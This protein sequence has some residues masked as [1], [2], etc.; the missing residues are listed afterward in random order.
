MKLSKLVFTIA[1]LFLAFSLSAQITLG[2]KAGASLSTTYGNP[3]SINGTDIESIGL[4]PG[5]LFGVQMGLPLNDRMQLISELN[6]D[7]RHGLKK[8]NINQS[9]PTPLGDVLVDVDARLE[10]T[11]TYLS[12]PVFFC[13]RQRQNTCLCRTKYCLSIERYY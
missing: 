10:N 12:L 13:L 1:C 9:I 4:R 8:I 2:V 5:Y 6:Y 3:E 11:F 7:Q